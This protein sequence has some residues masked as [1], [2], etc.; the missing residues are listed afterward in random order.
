M[1]RTPSVRGIP[2]TI[3]GSLVRG[4]D[5]FSDRP[6]VT[7]DTRSWSYRE[8]A[9]RVEGVVDDLRQAGVRPGDRVVLCAGNT[10]ESALLIWACARGGFVF[11]GLPT[12]VG[13]AAWA[14]LIGSAA[15][16]LVLAE[17]EFLPHLPGAISLT[18]ALTGRRLAWDTTLPHP[19]PADVYALV[20]TSGTTGVPKG[21]RIS[22]QATMQVAANYRTLLGLNRLD[23]TLIHLPFSYVSGHISQ[24]NPIMLSGGTAVIMKEFRARTL[25]TLARRRR[26]T[27]LDLVPWMFTM[28]LREPHFSPADLPALRAV[29]FGGATMPEPVLAAVIARFPELALFDVYGMSETAG[30]I[31]VRDVRAHPEPGGAP[32]PGIRVRL[33]PEGEL[34]VRGKATTTGYWNNPSATAALWR[35]GWL[36]TSDRAVIDRDGDIHVVGRVDDLINRAGVKVAPED[37]EHVL[38]L[39]P[40]VAECAAYGIPDGDAGEIVTAAV[41]PVEGCFVS[42]AELIIWARTRLPVHARPRTISVIRELPRN[43]T[44]KVDR[45]ALRNRHLC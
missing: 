13:P 32:A 29:I 16:A 9:E 44:G 22:H 23:V 27:V 17:E 37:V 33:S 15:P 12:H 41:V 1:T 38:S 42:P 8:F 5:R 25:L 31:S 35:G 45:H 26:A 34:L 3:V 10:L 6:L 2:A 19:D 24:L 11:A 18:A 4:L 43:P 20:Y 28:L 14:A 30:M 40:A 36:H 7:S 21:V 39:H